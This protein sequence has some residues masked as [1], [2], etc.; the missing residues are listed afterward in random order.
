MGKKI[1]VLSAAVFLSAVVSGS[2]NAQDGVYIDYSVL[3]SLQVPNPGF[4]AQPMF[5]QVNK[6][7]AKP[8]KKA[9]K[10]PVVKKK[11]AKPSAKKKAVVTKRQSRAPYRENVKI[12]D[13]GFFEAAPAEVKETVNAAP[14]AAVS[15]VVEMEAPRKATDPVIAP[16]PFHVEEQVINQVV[17]DDII[18]PAKEAV[19]A[20]KD[21]EAQNAE[22]AAELNLPV[23]PVAAKEEIKSPSLPADLDSV[24]PAATQEAADKTLSPRLE[25]AAPE[26]KV[27][28]EPLIPPAPAL[29]KGLSEVSNQIFFE[30]DSA[31]LGDLNQKRID[32]IISGFA[33][34]VNNKIA[35]YAYNLDN[36]QDVFKKKRLNL[37]RAVEV[38]SY[39]LQKGYKNFSIKV[40]NVTDQN[41]KENLVEIE[42]LK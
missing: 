2:A 19:N 4:S 13:T 12:I 37:N 26:V 28:P 7:T 40:I 9:A 38:R 1:L 22:A 8:D 23:A 17:T 6:S 33:D 34:P 39:L 21:M 15:S 20:S 11:A 42:E 25:E 5:P 16:E 27:A 10:K 31:E 24:A 14:V 30:A 3:D 41:E 35:I 36:G 32:A 29:V 18:I